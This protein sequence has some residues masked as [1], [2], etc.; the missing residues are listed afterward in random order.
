MNPLRLHHHLLSIA[1]AATVTLGLLAGV[2]GVAHHEAHS[3]L[4]A[5]AQAEVQ[6][7][8]LRLASSASAGALP[9]L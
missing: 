5:Q 4:A 8:A 1:L 3:G 2:G 9:T 6:A 7:Q